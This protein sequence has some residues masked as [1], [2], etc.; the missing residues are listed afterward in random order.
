M[1][2]YRYLV[3]AES[4]VEYIN[5][6]IVTYLRNLDSTERS[7]KNKKMTHLTFVMIKYWVFFKLQL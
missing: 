4:G 7:V 5:I 1:L 2:K 6:K 3:I